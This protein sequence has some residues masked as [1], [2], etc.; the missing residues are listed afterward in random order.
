MASIAT[1]E[2]PLRADAERNRQRL[3]DAADELFA[4][5]GLGVG[6]DEIARHA[7]VG[8]ATAY[9]RF[10]DKD[11]LIEALFE[12]RVSRIAKL[13]EAGLA[14]EDPWEGFVSF[15]VPALELHATNRGV[16]ELVF[17]HSSD[18]LVAKA[19]ARIMPV[20][21]E[22]VRRAQESGDLRRDVA[23]TDI[24]LFQFSL[25]SVADLGGPHI[26]G[27]W[28][29]QLGIVLDGLRTPK[30]TPLDPPPL[31]VRDFVET[32]GSAPRRAGPAT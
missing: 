26:E 20:V 24:P 10:P 16:K 32:M 17:G 29:R 27:Q 9:R 3:L 13:A 21:S 6:L 18:A 11:Q 5:K 30:P 8:V 23:V 19:R 14:N 15:F 25:S 28:R 22:L 31:S 7:G 12:E 1:E 2:R 4:E